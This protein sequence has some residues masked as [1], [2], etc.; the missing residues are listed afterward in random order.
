MAA[1]GS[2]RG[3][4]AD[5]RRH[6]ARRLVSPLAALVIA[7]VPAG[8]ALADEQNFK[9]AAVLRVVSLQMVGDGVL[10]EAEGQ[11]HSK[12]LGSFTV[13]ASI[14]QMLVPGCDPGVG[15][16]T[17]STEVGTL[18]LQGEALVCFTDVTGVWEVTGGRG[19]SP[20]RVGVACSPGPLATVAR[21]LSSST[22][23][24]RCRSDV[25]L[26]IDVDPSIGGV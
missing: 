13:T 11:G 12:L 16:F 17:I 19:T 8:A 26:M 10:I 5:M 22:S 20:E 23:R 4:E 24:A 15:E 6:L 14:G 3:K 25:L 18:V 1:H 21:I 2:E 7:A 9:A